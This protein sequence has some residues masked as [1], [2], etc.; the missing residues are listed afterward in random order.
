MYFLEGPL[1]LVWVHFCDKSS[2]LLPPALAPRQMQC[3]SLISDSVNSCSPAYE[4][5]AATVDETAHGQQKSSL[6][7]G[8]TQA[9]AVQHVNHHACFRPGSS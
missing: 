1:W 5:G 8:W 4:T 2:T 6:P 9:R 3:M 7:G